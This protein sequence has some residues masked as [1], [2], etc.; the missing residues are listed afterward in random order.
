MIKKI[1]FLLILLKIEPFTISVRSKIIYSDL[2]LSNTSGNFDIFTID[3]KAID[4]PE[5]TFWCSLQW[6]MDLTNLKKKYSDVQGGMAHGGFKTTKNG[7]KALISLGEITYREN[8][9]EKK[10]TPTRLYPKGETEK[11]IIYEDEGTKYIT[12]FEWESNIWY[13][14]VFRTWK[15]HSLRETFVGEW[16]Q[17]L[18][19]Q[20]WTLLAY[21]NT[22]LTDSFISGKLKQFQE[23]Y[24]E[25]FLGL[26]RSFQ[27][28]NIY[29]YD[30]KNRRWISLNKSTLSYGP[31]SLQYDTIGTHEFGYAKNYFYGSSGLPVE[32]QKI[33]DE[34]N[35]EFIKGNITQTPAP[36]FSEPAFKSLNAVV[37]EKKITINWEIDPKTCPCYEYGIYIYRYSKTEYEFVYN[38]VTSRP[39]VTSYSYS[40]PPFSGYYLI[41]LECKGISNFVYSDSVYKL[42]KN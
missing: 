26:E 20:K 11:E 34:S 35:P 30:K 1:L 27:I 18:S 41:T 5:N 31:P 7:K 12:E 36:L 6:Q 9:E 8:G 25:E 40:E 21:F 38:Y 22:H 23:D 4:I 24:N 15:D 13:R 33:Y 19:T 37:T 14:F 39:D 16:I 3:F 28:K 42:I 17:N 2:D 29:A 32:D 10:I